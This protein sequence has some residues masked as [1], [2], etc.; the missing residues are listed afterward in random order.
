MAQDGS[1]TI[2]INA[3]DKGLTSVKKNLDELEG[4]A[5]SGIVVKVTDAGSSALS[6]ID[7]KITSIAKKAASVAFTGLKVGA[8]GVAAGLTASVK[9]AGDLEQSV[10]G[11]DKIFGSIASKDVMADAKKAFKTAGLSMNEYLEGATSYAPKLL[12]DLGGN[13][14]AAGKEV[15]KAMV[16]M[17]DNSNTFG[18]SLSMLQQSYQGFS[19]GNFT[20]LDNLKL[21]YGGTEKEAMKLVKDAGVVKKNFKS[22]DDIS[23][24]EMIDSISVI[25]DRL[26]VTGTTAKEAATTLTGSFTMAKKSFENFLATGEGSDQVVDSFLNF[27]NMAAK[28]AGK[29]AP[30]LWAG[31]KSAFDKVKPKIPGLLADILGGA[32]STIGSM[33]GFKIDPKMFDGLRNISFDKI[34]STAKTAAKAI[35]GVVI[36]VKGLKLATSIMSKFGVS[37]VK[38]GGGSGSGGSNP[39]TA[40][41][42]FVADLKKSAASFI[43]QAGNLAIIY[44][45]VKVFEEI[46]SAVKQLENV[47]SVGTVG[48]KLLSVGVAVSAVGGAMVVVGLALDKIQRAKQVLIT[49]GMA[50]LGISLVMKSLAKAMKAIDD[51]VPEDFGGVAK[52]M[53]SMGIAVA[54]VAAGAA[55]IGAAI[56]A[57]GPIGAL[58]AG[59]GIGTLLAVALTMSSLAK[60]IGL[61]N[62]NVPNDFGDIKGKIAALAGAVTAITNSGLGNALD[63]VKSVLGAAQAAAA[64][65]AIDALIQISGKIKTLDSVGDVPDVTAKLKI[66]DKDIAQI[67]NASSTFG[68]VKPGNAA[69][70]VL[71]V[72]SFNKLIPALVKFN[73]LEIPDVTGKI[74]QIGAIMEQIQNASSTWGSMKPG[75]ITKA[76]TAVNN[77]LPLIVSL[78]ALDST[79]VPTGVLDKIMEIDSI[80]AQIQ[81]ATTTWGS[82]KPG[83]IIMA[84]TAADNIAA[85]VPKLNNMSIQLSGL[86]PVNLATLNAAI[87]Q[88]NGLSGTSGF[89]GLVASA[90]QAQ[91]AITTVGTAAVGA[92]NS[93]TLLDTTVTT[94]A[95]DMTALQATVTA[96]TTAITAAFISM[97]QAIVKAVIDAMNQVKSQFNSGLSAALATVNGYSA[98]FYSAGYNLGSSMADGI[99]SASGLISSAVA[100]LVS[101][102]TAGVAKAKSIASGGGLSYGTVAMENGLIVAAPDNFLASG[103]I[104]GLGAFNAN[105][106]GSRVTTSSESN[107]TVTGEMMGTN[108]PIVLKLDGQTVA[109]TIFNPLVKLMQKAK[110]RR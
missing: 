68:S 3:D 32:T 89:G 13:A 60:S 31:I 15:N 43:K 106:A 64:N 37:G 95:S 9:A 54:G 47:P 28:M 48:N 14:S 94:L 107:V 65:V 82:I 96:A 87:A 35:L 69:N 22:M 75:N 80:I 59:A 108:T 109:Q 20:M 74:K 38:G 78:K 90:T 21:G 100:N 72:N 66:L 77:M 79:A 46:V 70:A 98:L 18:T 53:L 99:S 71:A 56:V 51:N 39:F 34:A 84:G 93:V 103:A 17:S 104:S 97:T 44:G 101:Q 86:L 29:L 27:G 10:G 45:A 30:K 11:V 4:K 62:T 36:A 92:S 50:L 49:G 41:G 42:A 73:G 85:L 76:T 16:Q 40:K 110:V 52:K 57:A 5:K 23:F 26:H 8:L 91:S 88:L 1:L 2:K 19:K 83:N 63:M 61:I 6:S 7:G 25:Q 58:V 81:N 105:S 12:K 33:F 24:A 67:Q 102:A 55:L